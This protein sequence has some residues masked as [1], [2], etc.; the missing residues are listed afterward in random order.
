MKL[1]TL[2]LAISI[3]LLG[4]CALGPEYTRP[5]LALDPSYRGAALAE[6]QS[7]SITDIAWSEQF[8]D[9]ELSAVLRMAVQRNLDLQIA[10]TRIEAARAQSAIAKSQVLPTLSAGLST[11]PSGSAASDNSYSLGAVLNWELDIF[12]KL[13]RS[14][15]AAR[16]ELLASED[17]ARAV[18]S[19]LVATTAS[20][21]LNLRELDQELVITRANIKSQE[22]SLALVRALLRG[23]VASGAEEQQAIAQLAG[24]RMQ[25]PKIEQAI[26]ATENALSLLL[27]GQPGPI[28]RNAEGAMPQVPALP[29]AGL[30][31]ELLERR[32]D[33]RASEH[34]L[35]AA[36]ARIG[37]AIANRFP[38][39][40]IGLGGFFGLVGIDLGDTL[41]NDGVT[42]SVT[43]WGPNASL[44]LVDWG[45]GVNGVRGA[46][47]N[48]EIAALNYRATVLNAL[49]EVSNALT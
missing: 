8:Q 36:T 9:P 39:P 26:I 37:V 44:P 11:S 3:S 30:P 25:L 21:W 1:R 43:S 41:S 47:A 4:A 15:Q 34:A 49:R 14:N 22:E 27:G 6:A 2:T 18:M 19:T 46:R 38:V 40:T 17:G 48:A 31:S 13:R 42:Q 5:D 23:G 16:A 28:L 20:T 10:L 24:T 45:R 32:P 7:R 35:E 33:L 12:G 29:K